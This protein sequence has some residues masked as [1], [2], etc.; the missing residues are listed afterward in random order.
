[1][2][3][4]A[5][6]RKQLED[7]EKLYAGRDATAQQQGGDAEVAEQS[8]VSAS[9]SGADN[10]SE[11]APA[12][13]A[14]EHR[15]EG[16][17]QEESFEKRYKTL[18]GM[19]SAEVPR[20]HAEKRELTKR[21]QQLEQLISTMSAKPAAPQAPAQ[22]LVTEQDVAD[23]GDSID[24]MR[25]VVREE[26]AAKDAEIDE[27]KQLVRQLQ[28]TV[29]P[30]VHQL[31]QNYAVS[32]EQR[33]WADLQAAVPDW[34]DVN[35]DAG[36][37]AW[38]LE[39]DPLTGVPRQTYLEDAQRSLDSRRAANFFKAWKGMTGVPDARTHREAQP[40]SE[41]ER[42]IAPGKSRSGGN[43][44]QGATQT[45]TPAFIATFFADVTKGKYRGKEAERDRI[46]RDIFAA[47]REGRI[48][49][50]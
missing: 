7:V 23:Y 22:K 30:Q 27:L 18:Q 49:N 28:G 44:P 50:T 37:Q 20:L 33:F 17:T 40:A 36:F 4:P 32:N 24:V 15:P 6:V 38:L 13:K 26:V 25:K 35:V 3:L 11:Q 12:P 34:Q 21:V 48:V 45:Y 8:S 9:E 2:A 47:Q 10:V 39:V 31:S 16:D 42:Q 43:K 19:Y 1:M 29:V 46:E 5:Q 14:A 41:L